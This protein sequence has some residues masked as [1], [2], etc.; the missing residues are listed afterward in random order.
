MSLLL[1]LGDQV[2]PTP[3]DVSVTASLE[4]TTG[5]F[6]NL[7][8]RL[9]GGETARGKQQELDRYDAGHVTLTFENSDRALDPL[10]AAG[11]YYGTLVP[12]KRLDVTATY[13]GTTYPVIV[14]YVDRIRQV[15]NS[16]NTSQAVIEATD[17]FKPLSRAP[18]ATSVYAQ[19]VRADSPTHWWR[20][21]EPS[22]ATTVFDAVGLAHGAVT[23]SP[24]FGETS[25][26]DREPDTAVR[27]TNR[28]NRF[29]IPASSLP[30]GTAMTLEWWARRDTNVA[31]HVF[32]HVNPSGFTTDL[33][34]QM[35]GAGGALYVEMAHG[36]V[37]ADGGT[38]IATA[39]RYHFAVVLEVGQPIRFY[40]NGVLDS[41]V[42]VTGV[43]AA[44]PSAADWFV[45]ENSALVG[46]GQQPDCTIDEITVYDT[47][48]SSTRVAAHN[49]AG[50]TPW[51]GDLPG[52]RATRVLDAIAWP[53]VLRDLDTGITTLQGATLGTTVLEHLQK[54]AESEVGLLYVTREG[55]VRFE[56]RASTVNQ[57]SVATLTDTQG[58][59][60]A[61]TTDE[62][63]I[64]D[65][66]VRNVVTV[67]RSDGIAQ[68]ARDA[69]SIALNGP[70]GYSLDGLLNDSDALSLHIAEFILAE[71]KDAKQRI[72]QLNVV[73]RGNPTV[74]F[75]LVLALELS[76]VVTVKQKPQDVGAETTQ[77]S[78]VEGIT[79]TFGPKAWETSF[80]LSPVSGGTTGY[81]QLG[82]AGHSELGQTTVLYF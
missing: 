59:N 74:L 80:N 29:L 68:T 15:Y 16:P 61:I 66:L 1:L 46:T 18:L 62:P 63:E 73:P 17:A 78:V 82:V 8:S 76:D 6:A 23:G 35:T 5:V 41:T 67:S 3:G 42:A 39:T 51:T 28:D 26:V 65:D 79:H 53:L 77:V 64:T 54:V 45:A 55:V 24:A 20:L 12:N 56:D 49:A 25:L 2:A 19:E 72:N 9:M 36:T 50:R 11:A 40:V 43:V 4:T 32:D 30:T 44:V 71:F 34:V 14:G 13:N 10:N 7:S 47:A 22:G 33:T 37:H 21:G 52:A 60:P 38:N 57:T 58:S 27:I 81:W 69:T 75:P 48:L 70:A 31:F